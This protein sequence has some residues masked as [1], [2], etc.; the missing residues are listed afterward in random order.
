MICESC[1]GVLE[2]G[3]WP[4]CPDHGRASLS[5]V[6]DECDITQEHFGPTPEHFTS[7]QAMARRAKE[8]NLIP[9]VRHVGDPGSDKSA[10]TSRWI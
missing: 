8:L 3:S 9:M 7:K 1:G 10:K 6:G 4:F 2:I 5:V